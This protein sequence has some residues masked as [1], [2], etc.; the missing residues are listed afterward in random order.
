[1]YKQIYKMASTEIET[2]AIQRISDNAIIP[3]DKDNTDYHE[4]LKWLKEG[5]TPLPADED[6]VYAKK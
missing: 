2:K 1:M 5:N 3:F 6:I 4:Y